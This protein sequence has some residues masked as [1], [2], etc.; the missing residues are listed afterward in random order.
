MTPEEL[1]RQQIDGLLEESG[2]NV[3]DYSSMNIM[4]DLG[5]AIREFP[6]KT[7]HVDYLLYADG[8]AIGV[9]EAKPEGHTLKGVE[10][11]SAK[12][13]ESLPPTSKVCITTIQRLY[14]IL[15]DEELYDETNEEDSQFETAASLVK[16]PVPVVY[17]KKIPIETF[18]FII[19]DECH[20]SIYNVWRQVL[21]YF[22]GFLIGLTATPTAQTIGFFNG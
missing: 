13:T 9:V 22:D 10:I 4:A 18:D 1:A 21:D 17:S 12:Y 15:K 8:K 3:Q 14:S 20:R 7:G 2:W 5:V 16:E 6:V 11:Q 19:V